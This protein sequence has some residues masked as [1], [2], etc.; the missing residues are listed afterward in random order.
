MNEYVVSLYCTIRLESVLS[1][2]FDVSMMQYLTRMQTELEL[3][4]EPELI[5]ELELVLFVFF[6]K[7]V[8]FVFDFALS[9][10]FDDRSSSL[11]AFITERGFRVHPFSAA[12]PP[13]ISKNNVRSSK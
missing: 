6:S 13:W 12:G 11:L 5:L 2:I 7:S 3:E 10:T 1:A 8:L 4:L 9:Q